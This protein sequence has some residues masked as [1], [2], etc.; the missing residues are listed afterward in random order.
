MSE[1]KVI[2]FP[3]RDV[4]LQQPPITKE[5]IDS[6]TI[7]SLQEEPQ[8]ETFTT[9]STAE[10][11]K[12]RSESFDAGVQEGATQAKAKFDSD[13]DLLTAKLTNL[14]EK[15]NTLDK[16]H[17]DSLKELSKQAALL[18]IEVAKKMIGEVSNI[19]E[20]RLFKFFDEVFERVKNESNIAITLEAELGKSIA[21]K[22]K[23]IIADKNIKTNVTISMSDKLA[24]GECQIDWEHGKAIF[25]PDEILNALDKEI[26]NNPI[27]M[28]NVV[29]LENQTLQN[30]SL[31]GDI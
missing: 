23:S 10:L 26:K 27:S 12:I 13:S 9:I 25:N 21:D 29:G 17:Q 2:R 4:N 20:H 11:E 18:S 5:I 22:L 1:A 14:T 28:T 16:I 24:A 6:D 30:S 19:Q 31:S 7:N 3:L 15:I 8:T